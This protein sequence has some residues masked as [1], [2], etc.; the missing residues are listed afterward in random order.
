MVNWKDLLWG[1]FTNYWSLTSLIFFP[2]EPAT[3]RVEALVLMREVW[4]ACSSTHSCASAWHSWGTQAT[5]SNQSWSRQFKVSFAMMQ[6]GCAE[7]GYDIWLHLNHPLQAEHEDSQAPVA[8]VS[9]CLAEEAVS[10]VKTRGETKVGQHHIDTHAVI[11]NVGVISG[12]KNSYP[13]SW[14]TV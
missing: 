12:N 2:R 14:D 11:P 5:S 9:L 7:V 6:N 10:R 4:L 13:K 3:R 1:G 8:S